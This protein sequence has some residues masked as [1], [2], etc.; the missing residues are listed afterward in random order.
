MK[1][2]AGIA[3]L[4]SDKIDFKTNAVD[5]QLVR[6]MSQN[7]KDAGFTSGQGTYRSQPMSA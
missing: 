1:K 7:A 2:K 5:P 4:V 3:I 6:A